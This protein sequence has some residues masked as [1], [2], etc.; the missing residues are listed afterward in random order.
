L[1]TELWRRWLATWW[2]L[3]PSIVLASCAC[4]AWRKSAKHAKEQ[5]AALAEA[6]DLQAAVELQA[7]DED[8]SFAGGRAVP[9]K[10]GPAYWGD[11]T[12]E[13]LNE[14]TGRLRHA[15]AAVVMVNRMQRQVS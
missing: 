15:A 11:Q 1:T 9:L 13:R 4:V 7:F 8:A 5:E 12:S 2:W 6:K 3:F 10:S 14:E